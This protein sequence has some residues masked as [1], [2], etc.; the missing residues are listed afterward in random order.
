MVDLVIVGSAALDTIQTPFGK[1]EEVLGGSSIFASVAASYFSKPGLVTIV[2]D[3]FPQKNQEFLKNRGIDLEGLEVKGRTLR[4]HASYEYDMNEARTRKTELNAVETFQPRLPERYREA[5][6]VFL[7]NISPELQLMAL[8]QFRNPKF[9]VLDS[10]NL[11]IETKKEKLKEAIG[12]VDALLLNEG[13]A[14]MLFGTPN[15]VKAGSMAIKL[16]LKYFVI[17]K[18]EHGALLFSKDSFFSASGY[19]LEN[20]KDP[21]GCG[22]AFGGGIIG[23][24]ASRDDISEASMRKAVAYGSIIASFNA[25]DYSLNRLKTADLQ[26]IESRYGE[27][28]KM[29][30]F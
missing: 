11:W 19:P 9:V 13:E 7:G 4:W 29:N 12:K 21:T 8:E 5:K 25:E 1:V 20:L 22:D 16:G 14:R 28:K 30:E 6:Y 26:E 3:D 15:L 18:G 24:L 23:Y 17:K 2:G 10:M 27:F